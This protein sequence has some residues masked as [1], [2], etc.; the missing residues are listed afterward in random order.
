[1]RFDTTSFDTAF[2]KLKNKESLAPLH[3]AEIE[4]DDLESKPHLD[5]IDSFLPH[6]DQW[7]G[8]AQLRGRVARS[9]I[10]LQPHETKTRTA[11]AHVIPIKHIPGETSLHR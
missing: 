2:P 1:M 4:F 5:Y 9:A 3:T 7:K 11:A 8:C 10:S 6:S